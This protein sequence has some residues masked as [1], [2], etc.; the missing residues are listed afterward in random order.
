M[1]K[2]NFNYAIN[3]VWTW[4]Y[5]TMIEHI[6]HTAEWRVYFAIPISHLQNPI[7]TFLC[8]VNDHG[9]GVYFGQNGFISIWRK[10][11]SRKRKRGK[12]K[13]SWESWEYKRNLERKK[14][15]NQQISNSKIGWQQ[16][17]I[18]FFFFWCVVSTE[19]QFLLF[20]EREMSSSTVVVS[21]D[22]TLSSFCLV[23][24][25]FDF[26]CFV[27]VSLTLFVYLLCFHH[28]VVV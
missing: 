23:S 7:I 9:Q 25:R 15:K 18:W 28:V 11:K 5:F 21:V 20:C 10:S 12:K 2:I 1:I 16:R 8:S 19:S 27:H 4:T 24:L 22:N 13:K 26:A 14:M 17:K 6:P 3:R